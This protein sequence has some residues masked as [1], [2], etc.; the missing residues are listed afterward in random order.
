MGLTTREVGS[1]SF[2]DMISSIDRRSEFVEN[3]AGA[4]VTTNNALIS[5]GLSNSCSI[6]NA[7]CG[8]SN[9]VYPSLTPIKTFGSELVTNGGFD[10]DSDWTKL[11]ATISDGK[12]NLDGDG[13]TSLLYQNILTQNKF[14]KVTFTVS[15]YNEI[16]TALIINNNGISYYAITTNG[17]FTINFTHTISNGNFLFRAT[18]GAIFSIDN[19][20]VKEVTEADFDFTRG[21]SAT[22]VNEKGL[23][24]DVQILS[25]NLVQNGDFSQIGS[26][27]VT[28]G[29]FSDGS[30][31]WSVTGLASISNGVASFVDNG[32]NSNAYINQNVFTVGKFYKV[33]FDITRYVAGRIQLQVNSLY[34]VDISGGVGTYTTYV[35]SD[36]I[37]LLIKRDGAYANYDFD[38]DNVSVKEVGQNWT[39][40]GEA[41]FTDNGARIYS[42]SGSNSYIG[43]TILTN[44]KKYKLSYEIVDSTQGGLKLINV[45]G[46]SDYSIPSTLGTHS[47]DFIANNP[48]FFILRDSGITDVTIDNISV[49]EITDDTDLPRINYTNFDYEN[50]EV[51]PYS[52]EGSLLLE[53]QRSNGLNYSEPTSSEYL[54]SGITYESFDWSLGFTNCIKF[55]DNSQT[56]YR[57]FN[58]TIANSTEY[59]I[60]AFVIMDDLSEPVLGTASNNGDFIFRVG[61]TTATTGNLPNVNMGNNIYRVSSVITSDVE[62]GTTGLLKYSGQSNKGFR[63]VGFQVEQGSYATSYI[64]TN[65]STVTRLADVC[66]NAGSSDLINSTEGVLYAEIKGFISHDTI[67]PNR[68]ITITNGTS[69]ER[70][71]LLLGGNSNQLRAIIYSSTQS[72]NLSFTTSLT[73]VKQ[74]NKLAVKYKSG[75]YAFFLNGV[76]IDSSTITNYFSENTLNDLSFDVGGGTQQFRGNVKCVAVFKEALSDS[77]L[78]KLTTI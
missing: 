78:Q 19:V 77:E 67:E 18:N 3:R 41:E 13:Q 60:S 48:S 14:Y 62:G 23:I 33:T 26:E 12:G 28:N 57:Y 69:N 52:G 72:I 75:D 29:D 36:N 9:G 31:G 15:D 47:I 16:G 21:S 70:V 20:S 7:P 49:I 39:F 34:S 1:S 45:N 44:T 40:F 11:N 73:D 54:A 51:V 22:R 71:A 58:G 50:G 10:T 32:T 55:G 27:E 4:N 64:P 74:Y 8:Y 6:L 65:G 76:K 30:T 24:E 25:G 53:P 35:K 43:Q 66:N 5:Y 56:R 38:I 68:Y 17:T 2:N 59:T 46:V 42:S 37:R 63:I 61:G